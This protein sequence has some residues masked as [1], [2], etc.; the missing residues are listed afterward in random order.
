MK[1]ILKKV[2]P[3]AFMALAVTGSS[4]FALS[5]LSA[6][7]AAEAETLAA[8]N[9]EQVATVATPIELLDTE[10]INFNP[11]NGYVYR[12]SETFK[13]APDTVEVRLKMPLGSMG[14]TLFGNYYIA[15]YNYPG[16]AQWGI[17]AIGRVTVLWDS[18]NFK[19]TFNNVS[20]GDGLWHHVAIVH[21]SKAA[22]FTLYIDGE[23]CDS[24]VSRQ[25]DLKAGAL[26]MSIGVDYQTFYS[27]KTPFEGY[28]SQ[29]TVYNGPITQERVREDM[30]TTEI[31]DDYNGKIM[32]NWYLGEEWTKR[33]VTDSTGS[34]V[35]ASIHTTMKYVRDA[36][37]DYEYDYSFI[38]VP[39]IQC[40]VRYH[41]STFLD[42]MQWL[43]DNGDDLKV[44]WA[45]F[46]G[47]LSDVGNNESLYRSASLGMSLLDGKVNYN[48]VPGN[49][50]YDSNGQGDRSQVYFDTWFP[51]AKHS[52]MPGFMGVYE[53]G[54]MANSYYT[55]SV[56]GVDYLII[57]L[58]YNPRIGAIRWAGRLCEAFPQHRV[59]I[60][61]H[62]YIGADGSISDS[63][64][65]SANWKALAQ[66][67]EPQVL[68]DNL[69]KLYPNIWMVFSGHLSQDDAIMRTDVGVHGNTVYSWLIDTQTAIHDNGVGEDHLFIL[70][71]N[72]K[73]KK[74][75]C[76]LYSPANDGVY[77]IQNQF[78]IDFPANCSAY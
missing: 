39:D 56:C 4:F 23:Y 55:Y 38:E 50:D 69:V 46:L 15:S 43:A 48:F 72:E 58:E 22:S 27:E 40:C 20:L 28:I 16:T 60:A 75:C 33:T 31:T 74:I 14:G 71:V 13:L 52:K 42:M 21:D 29:V 51:Y 2:I 9:A 63:M 6:A 5:G 8:T 54:S 24:V 61:T 18:G 10:S 68:Y 17:D 25:N 36:T 7:N 11:M 12:L 57:N 19:Y 1:K 35:D 30:E 26:P 77:N 76:L 73:T 66:V 44:Q 34:G 41:Y 62:H 49:H 64:W 67:T 32:G 37:K 47:D 53:V 78:E 59:I 65:G 3:A 45:T 70:K